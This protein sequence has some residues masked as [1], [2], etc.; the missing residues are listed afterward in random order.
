MKRL[1]MA[2]SV[3]VLLGATAFAVLA[4][5]AHFLGEPTT[6]HTPSGALSASGTVAGLGNGDVTVV[7]SATGSRTCINQGGN[8]PPGQEQ[9][10]SGSQTITDVKNGRIT[11]AVTTGT[12]ANTCPDHMASTVSFT[13]ATL[14]IYQGG[15]VVLQEPLT[16]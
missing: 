2:L 9:T 5:N 12:L 13:S 10:V 8:P 11:F 6:S 14:T 1:V 15:E 4:A 7:L 3:L 16:P